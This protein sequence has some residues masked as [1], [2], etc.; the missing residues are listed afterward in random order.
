MLCKEKMCSAYLCHKHQVFP[1][2]ALHDLG[3]KI[4]EGPS[5]PGQRF[6]GWVVYHF[7]NPRNVQGGAATFTGL[8]PVENP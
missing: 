7:K 8:N 4:Q 3:G 2:A 5:I 1:A 6:W